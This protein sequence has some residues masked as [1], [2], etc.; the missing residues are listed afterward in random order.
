MTEADVGQELSLTNDRFPVVHPGGNSSF[1]GW[2]SS[3][4]ARLD[5]PLA[6]GL[7]RGA[8]SALASR[9]VRERFHG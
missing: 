7:D 9:S 4:L 5:L 6:P 3:E 2:L 8:N 1:A